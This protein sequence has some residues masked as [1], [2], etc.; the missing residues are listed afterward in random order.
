MEKHTIAKRY[1]NAFKASI[2]EATLEKE[3]STLLEL[4]N[5]L[6]ATPDILDYLNS[7]TISLIN[8]ILFSLNEV[9]KLPFFL[10]IFL[11]FLK[12]NK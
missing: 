11:N 7:P 5:G 1:L 8:L 9:F 6:E 2:N 3:L 10:D 12:I 4:I